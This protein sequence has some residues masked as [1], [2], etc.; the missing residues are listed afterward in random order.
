MR[1]ATLLLLV[2][3]AAVGSASPTDLSW[4]AGCWSFE[5]D[6]LRAEEIWFAPTADG[7]MGMARTLRAG[8]VVNSEFT[9]LAVRDGAVHYVANPSGQQEAAFRL[10]ELKGTRAVFEDPQHDF[11]TRIV[12]HYT[13]PDRL[14]ARIEGRAKGRDRSEDYPFRRAPCPGQ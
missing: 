2:P 13:A 3:V 11:P 6:G 5:R 12:Y 4:L 8:K 7:A 10:V 1:L 9:R 14:D